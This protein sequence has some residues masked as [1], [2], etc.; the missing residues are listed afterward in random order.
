MSTKLAKRIKIEANMPLYTASHHHHVQKSA[1]TK[2]TV[3]IYNKRTYKLITKNLSGNLVVKA[4]CKTVTF[5]IKKHTRVY[6]K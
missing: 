5:D 3:T 6:S 1:S 2:V 4:L